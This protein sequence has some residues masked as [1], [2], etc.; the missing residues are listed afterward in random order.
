MLGVLLST[1]G[2]M[3]S[4]NGPKNMSTTASASVEPFAVSIMIFS[5]GRKESAC[6]LTSSSS[7]ASS[8]VPESISHD[9]IPILVPSMW[10][11]VAAATLKQQVV[12]PECTVLVLAVAGTSPPTAVTGVALIELALTS[13]SRSAASDGQQ[14]ETPLS[15]D[16]GGVA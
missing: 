9:P 16:F 6:C 10:L 12:E 2:E 4:P 3:H 11:D 13:R 15:A 5:P 8:G 7:T 14:V 1:Y